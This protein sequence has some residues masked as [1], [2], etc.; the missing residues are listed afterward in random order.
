MSLRAATRGVLHVI[1]AATR[2]LARIR[3][4]FVKQLTVP[5]RDRDALRRRSQARPRLLN[6]LRYPL[7]THLFT[8][9]EGTPRPQEY[10]TPKLVDLQVVRDIGNFIRKH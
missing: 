2:D 4:S 10:S 1:P 9:G 8:A 6:E 7:L 5:V 3:E